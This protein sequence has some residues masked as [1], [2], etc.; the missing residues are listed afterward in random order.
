MGSPTTAAEPW[1]YLE[2]T[3]HR[4][5]SLLTQ[6]P[7]PC[8][9]LEDGRWDQ[10]FQASKYGLVILVTR[11]HLEAIQ[12]PTKSHFTQT[13]DAPIIQE[14][15]RVLGVLHQTPLSHLPH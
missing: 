15:P 12:E 6:S 13:K 4:H 10:K 8:P 7:A 11:R 5:D 3:S 9:S 2:A 1:I 14:I